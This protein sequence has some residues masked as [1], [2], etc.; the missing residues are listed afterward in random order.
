MKNWTL[1]SKLETSQSIVDKF[2][3]IRFL[4]IY[5]ER[6]KIVDALKNPRVDGKNF[7]IYNTNE[8][9]SVH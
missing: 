1:N 8:T 7:T 6:N 5:R 3:E 9:S 2:E 4:H